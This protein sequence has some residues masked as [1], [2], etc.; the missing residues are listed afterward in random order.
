ML[1]NWNTIRCRLLP[2][3]VSDAPLVHPPPFEDVEIEDQ[4]NAGNITP[5]LFV[6]WKT[7]VKTATAPRA[8]APRAT[9]LSFTLFLEV[10]KRLRMTPHHRQLLITA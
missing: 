8:T 2:T 9:V 1:G 7:T 3:P 4:Q 6:Y 10:W 5:L